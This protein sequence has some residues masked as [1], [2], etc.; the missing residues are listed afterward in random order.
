MQETA[1]AQALPSTLTF[2]VV[3]SVRISCAF[4]RMRRRVVA[5]RASRAHAWARQHF[6]K[7]DAVFFIPL[8]YS[9]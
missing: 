1:A 7:Q 4:A 9:G 2:A 6:L 8:V 5:Q 3:D